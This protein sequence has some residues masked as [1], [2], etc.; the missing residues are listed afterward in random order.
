V[1]SDTE[2]EQRNSFLLAAGH[3]SIQDG[4]AY[5]SL[6]DALRDANARQVSVVLRQSNVIWLPG[7]RY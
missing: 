2:H 4:V 1:A 3:A 6:M 7:I 5:K